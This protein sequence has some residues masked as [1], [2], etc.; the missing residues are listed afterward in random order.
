VY[1][2]HL[3]ITDFRNISRLDKDIPCGS[4]L[5]VGAN[6]QGKTSLLEAIYFLATMTSFRADSDR[7]LLNL[8]AARQPLAVARIVAIYSQG[9]NSHQ[10]EVRLIQEANGFNTIPKIR[11]EVLLDGLKRKI[12]EVIG[13][14]TA[15]L[16]SPQMISVIEGVPDERRR[17]L[18]LTLAQVLPRYA[19]ALSD[20]TQTLTQRNALLKQLN[21]RNGDNNQLDFWD[22]CLA[23]AGSRL[24]YAR[25]HSIQEIEDLA[26][27]IHKELTRQSGI[28]RLS[29]H[30]AYEPLPAPTGQ[31]ILPLS[32]PKNRSGISEDQIRQGFLEKLA[33]QRV[34]E[35][36]RGVTT[37]G[38]HRDELRFLENGIDLG[39]YGSRGQV[40]TA[41][42][43]LK[44]AEVMWMREKKNGEP[45]VLL[46][47]EMLAEL[48][49][50]RRT[51]LLNRLSVA[52]QTM[53]TTTDLDLFSMEF[54]NRANIWDLH[55]GE[56]KAR[57]FV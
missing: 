7:P 35:I 5:F 19:S 25:I 32:I 33:R 29:Y 41:M 8:F 18:N 26:A 22:E 28:L 45:P 42:L 23:S 36:A 55:G 27:P 54:I 51:D 44:L 47:D 37:I 50:E 46:L 31:F 1:L 52:E 24:I 10:I 48:D 53:L 17:Y 13:Q 21:E 16:F 30:P 57:G 40:R 6:A 56:V 3:S 38:P 34:E 20:Y 15:V 12:K 11:K 4:L 2:T 9:G 43:S 39:I 14:F 49:S